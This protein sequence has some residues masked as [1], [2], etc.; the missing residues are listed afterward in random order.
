MDLRTPE[1]LEVFHAVIPCIETATCGSS[2]DCLYLGGN[3]LAKDL[4]SKIVVCPLAWWWD[5]FKLRGYTER[6]ACSLIDSFKYEA[7][8][9]AD[10]S[11]FD[12]RTWLVT[13]QF[14]NADD[15][16]DRVEAELGFDGNDGQSLDR[17]VD[18]TTNTK[19]SFKIS[20]DYKAALVSS[21]NDLNM[22]LTANSHE[23]AK[24]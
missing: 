15:F 1:G 6:T 12:E 4:S 11:A 8:Q 7:L 17:Y 19:T 14:A 20:A 21:L 22:D 5:L 13:T 3:K 2:I 24:L 10:Q 23:S 18:G 9:L 16:L